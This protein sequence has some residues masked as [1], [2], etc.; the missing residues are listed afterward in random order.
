MNAEELVFEWLDLSVLIRENSNDSWIKSQQRGSEVQVHSGLSI[1]PTIQKSLRANI[2]STGREFRRV[3]RGLRRA[4]QQP[5]DCGGK[6]GRQ[7][8]LRGRFRATGRCGLH[9]CSPRCA[10]SSQAELSDKRQ[11]L[12]LESYPVRV[13]EDGKRVADETGYS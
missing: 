8:R 9:T 3:R 4:F 11:F 12:Y 13:G 10:A 6:D 1:V 7:L 2:K 5:A